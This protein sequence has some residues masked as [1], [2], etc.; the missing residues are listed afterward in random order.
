MSHI[1]LLDGERLPLEGDLAIAR[2]GETLLHAHRLDDGDAVL[3]AARPATRDGM[4]LVGQLGVVARGA[5]GTVLR[6]GGLKLELAW[7]ARAT[8]RAARPSDRCR[9]CFGGCGAGEV[10]VC[11]A[12]DAVFDPACD[13]ARLDCPGCGA[14]R[15]EVP[16]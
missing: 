3:V 6:A 14:P 16:A 2:G 4:P 15:A 9:L 8:R 12:C 11:P 10:A 13:A 1:I 5:A 7:E